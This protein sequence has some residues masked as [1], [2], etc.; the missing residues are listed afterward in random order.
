MLMRFPEQGIAIG[1]LCNVSNANTQKRAEDVADV[2]LAKAFPVAKAVAA[3]KPANG[4]FTPAPRSTEADA[5][6]VVGSYLAK[7]E[8]SGVIIAL[9]D[10]LVML[11]A[12]VGTF[13]LSRESASRWTA[14]GGIL[15]VDIADGGQSVSLAIRGRVT[16]T[17]TR[18]TTPLP[19]AAERAAYAGTYPSPELGTTWTIRA[20]GDTLRM[21]GRAVG[22]STLRPLARD[23]FLSQ[24]GFVRFTRGGDGAVNGF[25]LT[26]SRMRKIRFDRR[27]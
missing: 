12:P 18:V 4:T 15:A 21:A 13:P 23:V 10:G 14:L 19:S 5:A 6:P 2:V 26:A 11:S 22:E 17:F 8:Q 9:R 25:D 1:V 3:A 7:D 20:D 16:G 27:P 24:G